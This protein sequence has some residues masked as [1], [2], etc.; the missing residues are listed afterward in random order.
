MSKRIASLL[1]L[2]CSTAALSAAPTITTTLSARILEDDNLFLQ[3]PTPLAAGQ[4]VVGSPADEADGA[5]DATAAFGVAWKL[6]PTTAIDA[7][8]A[9]EAVRYFDHSSED[10]TDHLL[11]LAASTEMEAWSAELKARYLY[12][13]GSDLSPIYNGVGGSSAVGGEPVRARRAQVIARGSGKVT[14]RLSQGFV[15]GVVSVFDQRFHTQEQTT[16]GYCNYTDRDESSVGIDGGMQ[17]LDK[18]CLV[19]GA[20]TGFQRQAN[21]LNVPLN[22][23]NTFT[24]WLAGVEGSPI[25]SLKLAFLAGPEIHHYG[26]SVRA[27]YERTQRTGYTEGSATWT[28]TKA[29]T[30]ALSGRRYLWLPGGGRGVYVDTIVDLGW[31]RKLAP[32]WSGALGTNYHEGDTGHFNAWAPR[33][34]RVYTANAG[35]S[36]L[37]AAKT[38]LDVDVL[39]DWGVSLV[40]NQPGREYSRWILSATVNQSW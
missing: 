31:R 6:A 12:V 39:H 2:V 26:S 16:Y 7:G 28:P 30:V 17:V 13:D 14:R 24:R 34:D 19:L 5:I 8:Y 22:F 33:W 20:R 40:P 1:A 27:G 25:S 35:V 10:H 32:G 4:T 9:P 36:R 11:T 15:R 18:T 21:V 38:R 23:S 37:F 29:D 3:N